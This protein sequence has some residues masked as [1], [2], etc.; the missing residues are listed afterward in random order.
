MFYNADG[1]PDPNGRFALI[2]GRLKLRSNR[3]IKHGEK[4]GFELAFMTDSVSGTAALTSEE[5]EI[6][7][8]TAKSK[9][10]IRHGYLPAHQ[11]PPF[12]EEHRAAAVS[13][14]QERKAAS[15]QRQQTVAAQEENDPSFRRG[16]TVAIQT[17]R[18]HLISNAWRA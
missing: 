1:Q 14:A 6:A 2:D 3:M 9:H 5:T 10:D 18:K 11:R 17:T 7:V 12:T 15:A 8:A 16:M 4:V 13:A